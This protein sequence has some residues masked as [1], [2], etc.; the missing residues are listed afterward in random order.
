VRLGH[1]ERL[2]RRAVGLGRVE[3]ESAL[4]AHDH[5][6]FEQECGPTSRAKPS[7][8]YSP[9]HFAPQLR[10]KYVAARA[11]AEDG[12]E[13]SHAANQRLRLDHQ[14][15]LLSAAPTGAS[16]TVFESSSLALR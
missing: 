8:R 16:A 14:D 13:P 5:A 15:V 6:E 11:S 10:H 1:V 3:L 4:V 9:P 12:V 2:A 7:V